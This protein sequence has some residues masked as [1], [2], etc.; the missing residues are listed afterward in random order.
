MQMQMIAS[1]SPGGNK[2]GR[3]QLVPAI[4]SDQAA[5]FLLMLMLARESRE[6]VDSFF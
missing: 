6:R 3:K 1:H 5:N 4:T 2:L